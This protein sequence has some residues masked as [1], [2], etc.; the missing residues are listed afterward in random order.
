MAFGLALRFTEFGSIKSRKISA[1]LLF[2]EPCRP[3]NSNIGFCVSGRQH[4]KIKAKTKIWSDSADALWGQAWDIVVTNTG[5]TYGEYIA[6]LSAAADEAR[7]YGLDLIAVTDLLTY[8]VQRELNFLPGASLNGTI[9]HI[10]TEQLTQ[11]YHYLLQNGKGMRLYN[12][13]QLLESISVFEEAANH[14]PDRLSVNL[15]AAQSFLFY[16]K[17]AGKNDEL[18]EKARHFLDV[19]QKLDKDNER[20][21]KLEDIYSELS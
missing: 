3:V 18:L 21:Q 10:D 8:M 11:K 7:G 9:S 19:S 6:A 14:L 12:N 1:I 13:N 17:G 20:Y 15:N 2:P 16:M 5:T 4:S